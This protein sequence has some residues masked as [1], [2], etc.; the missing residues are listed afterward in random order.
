MKIDFNTIDSIYTTDERL[1]TAEYLRKPEL[2]SYLINKV[3]NGELEMVLLRTKE[4][5]Q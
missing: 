4:A 1:N 5:T 3:I 2:V